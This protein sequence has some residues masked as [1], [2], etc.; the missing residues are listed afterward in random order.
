MPLTDTHVRNAKPGPKP[1][2]MADGGGLYLL[3]NPQGGKWWRLDYRFDG[4]RK[5]L[6]CGTYPGVSLKDARERRDAARKLLAH[7]VDPGEARKAEKASRVHKAANTFEAVAREWFARN[8]PGW[9]PGH[10]SK[11]IGRLEKDVFPWLGAR[12]IAD[13]SAPELLRVLRR[14]EERGA[15]ETAHRTQQNCG[16]VFRFAICT[17]RAERNP[18]ADLKG[19]LPPSRATH[20]AT[21]TDPKAIGA[22]LRAMDSYQGSNVTRCAL[23][24]APL[25]FVRPGEL[26]KAEWAEI[27]MGKAE[28]R[29]PAHKMKSRA[30]H[31][32][33]LP[34]QAL[35]ILRE[36]HPLTGHGRYLFPSERTGER[37]MSENTVNAALRRLGFTKEEITGHGFRAMASTTLNEKGWSRDA[38]ERQLA[39]AER[40]TVRAAYNHAEHLPERS[41]MMQ[42]W[43]DHLGRLRE[44]GEIVPLRRGAL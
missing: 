34:A 44:G 27:D 32:V 1:F 28:W 29:I 26:R 33:P 36:L 3:V 18:A 41:K 24:L 12:P 7:G 25:V 42:W 9:A 20:Y 19:A 39:H 8:S 15:L 16:M 13:I 22:L 40:D 21:I 43:A 6:A 37:P 14:I 2:K 11:I 17:G 30:M 38:I 31:V 35:E 23:L 5:T 10:A 4:R